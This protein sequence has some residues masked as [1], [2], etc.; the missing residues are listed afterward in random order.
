M[1]KDNLLKTITISESWIDYSINIH[2]LY[3]IS[4]TKIEQKECKIPSIFYLLPLRLRSFHE[5][6][7]E[8]IQKES[9]SFYEKLIS[10]NGINGKINTQDNLIL[11]FIS[12]LEELNKVNPFDF[13]YE[14][15][16]VKLVNSIDNFT[17]FKGLNA[18]LV[19]DRNEFSFDKILKYYDFYRYYDCYDENDPYKLNNVFYYLFKD[20]QPYKGMKLGQQFIPIKNVIPYNTNISIL[21][22]KNLTIKELIDSKIYETS[23]IIHNKGEIILLIFWNHTDHRDCLSIKTLFN[24]LKQKNFY[25]E[26]LRVIAF[27]GKF[28]DLEYLQLVLDRYKID[29]SKIEF[30][31]KS[32]INQNI[33]RKLFYYQYGSFNSSG[34]PNNFVIF[35]NYGT[36][37]YFGS[38]LIINLTSAI[39]IFIKKKEQGNKLIP[40]IHNSFMDIDIEKLKN[41]IENKNKCFIETGSFKKAKDSVFISPASAAFI[42]PYTEIMINFQR[43]YLEKEFPDQ[44]IFNFK[45]ERYITFNE[46]FEIIGENWKSVIVEFSGNKKVIEY[47]DCFL[48]GLNLELFIPKQ[49]LS[50]KRDE[51]KL[52][53]IKKGDVCNL[54]EEKLNIK[55]I[56]YFCNICNIYLCKRCGIYPTENKNLD[57]FIHKH[58][59]LILPSKFETEGML[60]EYML[61]KMEY[62]S[63][64]LKIKQVEF[65]SI[66]ELCSNSVNNVRYICCDCIHENCEDLEDFCYNCYDTLSGLNECIGEDSQIIIEK[67]IEKGHI[68]DSHIMIRIFDAKTYKKY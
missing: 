49:V 11:E 30:Y 3:S 9:P 41:K 36:L 45:I 29:T 7:I 24:E 6:I 5:E 58:G 47:I 61:P 51:D 20:M 22:E 14:D 25:D 10:G 54:C 52:V 16:E 8:E 39:E 31:L 64:K 21:K 53:V 26:K 35:D 32:N 46:K 55:D 60:C 34:I 27:G 66:C 56:Q 4:S 1:E 12:I 15:F 23:D 37:C 13:S 63:N 44:S 2:M 40:I 67:A 68:H 18:K 48:K 62:D 33:I 57:Y 28:E 17:N 42:I 59:M 43:N 38:I 50:I 19:P 65:F